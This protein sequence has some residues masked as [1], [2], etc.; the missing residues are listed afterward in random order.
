M[1][2]ESAWRGARCTE[3]SQQGSPW[4]ASQ[5]RD[6]SEL[7]K[8]FEE[9]PSTRQRAKATTALRATRVSAC[10]AQ[11]CQRAHSVSAF[12]AAQRFRCRVDNSRRRAARGYFLAPPAAS[13]LAAAAFLAAFS[14]SAL[15]SLRG[16]PRSASQRRGVRSERYRA[17]LT[18]ARRVAS[19]CRKR[20]RG[21]WAAL[22]APLLALQG[23]QPILLVLRLLRVALQRASA[24][25]LTLWQAQAAAPRE[26]RERR[27]C[28]SG[29]LESPSAVV[30]HL[31]AA[32]HRE[33]SRW[34]RPGRRAPGLQTRVRGL[35]GGVQYQILVVV[36][37]ST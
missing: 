18:V 10:R 27:S 6:Q 26:R 25:D 32:S 15:A 7:S 28:R 20:Q 30:S 23:C 33:S 14:A 2:H 34:L 8:T 21:R 36:R 35:G 37:F 13:P 16:R 9:K 11:I 24:V 19:A 12:I 5:A 3:P 31:V 17:A 22:D 4:L 1:S 29:A